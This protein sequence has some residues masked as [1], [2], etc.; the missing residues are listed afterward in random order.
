MEWLHRGVRVIRR[1]L[2]SPP[3]LRDSGLLQNEAYWI[4]VR[5]FRSHVK[6]F[7]NRKYITIVDYTKASSCRRLYMIDLESGRVQKHFVSHGKNSG[8]LYATKF[9]NSFDSYQSSRGFFKTGGKYHGKAGLSLR[10]HGLQKGINDNAL[11]RGIVMHGGRYASGVSRNGGRLGRSWGCPTI[12]MEV[13][14]NV[15]DKIKGGS[16]LYM[17]AK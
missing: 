12:P 13:A 7:K 9:S 8:M 16:L 4:A 3:A 5:F 14:D 17:H 11:C 2:P 15:I 1:P 6:E 10:L